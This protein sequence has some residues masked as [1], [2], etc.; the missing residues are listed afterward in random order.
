[1][2]GIRRPQ[3]PPSHQTDTAARLD[4]MWRRLSDRLFARVP[5]LSGVMLD[6]ATTG[7]DPTVVTHGLGR[8]PSGWIVCD[9]T[10]SADAQSLQRTAWDTKSLSLLASAADDATWKV[11]VF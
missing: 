3:I 4:A 5:F 11:W 10:S 8:T 9:H 2:S 6:V 7:T 1:M